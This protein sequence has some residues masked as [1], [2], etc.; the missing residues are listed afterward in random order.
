MAQYTWKGGA[1]P[2]QMIATV[3]V[4]SNTDTQTFTISVRHPSETAGGGAYVLIASH[5]ASSNSTAQIAQELKNDWD[6]SDHELALAVSVE[7]NSNVLTFTSTKPGVPFSITT[8]GTG[9]LT[10]A[11]T[12][13]NQG[14]HDW[15]CPSNWVEGA[16]PADT[17]Q[18]V[19]T[20]Q[21]DIRYNLQQ[22]S[23]LTSATL[24]IVNYSGQLGALGAP[25]WLDAASVLMDA[26]AGIAHIDFVSGTAILV[27]VFN[28]RP[29]TDYGL[30]LYYG[31]V[32]TLRVHAGRVA[33]GY[34]GLGTSTLAVTT[35]QVREGGHVLADSFCTATTIQ[36][37]GTVLYRGGNVTTITNDAGELTTELAST[38]TTLSVNGGV[39]YPNSSGT[40]TTCNADGG[41]VDFTNNRTAR[42]VSTMNHGRGGKVR[43]VKSV[44]T[45][46]THNE[47][48][49]METKAAT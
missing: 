4:N 12:Q 30:Y 40:I 19:I 48:G 46:T 24:Q 26:Q 22:D 25:L 17:A 49:A 15:E 5:T 36:N 39:V 3:T 18:I 38:V 45:F 43:R 44:V 23:A 37:E 21:H 9:T 2:L 16:I 28:T 29:T 11:V 34:L 1:T 20:G 47:D 14:P 7:I 8:G 42:T 31:T 13:P 35:L 41:M 32:T 33:C 27:E 6:A 10:L